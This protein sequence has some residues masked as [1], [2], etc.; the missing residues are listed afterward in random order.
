MSSDMNNGSV[1]AIKISN[2][3]FVSFILE[4]CLLDLL[5]YHNCDLFTIT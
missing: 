5:I 3:N 2:N 4:D 1:T